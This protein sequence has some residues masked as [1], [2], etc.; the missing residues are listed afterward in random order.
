MGILE[1]ERAERFRPSMLL[2]TDIK[3]GSNMS[4]DDFQ[5]EEGG[6]RGLAP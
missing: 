2:E 3:M 1:D 5:E 4:F 6:Q